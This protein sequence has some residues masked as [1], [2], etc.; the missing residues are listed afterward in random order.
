MS[1]TTIINYVLIALVGGVGSVLANKGIA[2]FNDGLRPIYPE[3]FDHKINRRELALTSFGVSFGLIIGFGIPVSIGSTILLAHSILLACDIFGTWTPDNKWGATAAFAIGAVYGAGLLL[4]LSWIVK[5][6]KMLPFNF[7]GA[8]S[9]LGSPILLAFC[10]FPAIA[11]AEQHNVKKGLITFVW[12]FV[13]YILISKFGIFNLGNGITITLNATGMALL[14]AMICMVYYAAKVKGTN[15]SNENL[16]NVFSA[17]IGRIKKNWIWLSLM[18]GLITAASSELILAV[19]VLPQQLLIKGQIQEAAMATFARAIGFIPLVFS[20][21]IVTGVYGMAGT[22]L[23][24]AIGLL[25]KGQPLVAFIAGA[26]WMWIEVQALGATAKGMDKFPGL[27]DMGDHIRTSLMETI[28]TSL[29]IGAAIACNKMA[30]N[31]GFFWVIGTWLLNK[32][33]KKPLVDMAVGPIATIAL[34]LLLNILRIV[35]LF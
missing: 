6:F 1:M 30:P 32:K 29:L 22:T 28:S 11:V 5:L 34:G 2:V 4:G 10:A 18:G 13:T 17:R 20:T 24:F 8:L 26:V 23:I 35:H 3:Y 33:M 16:V 21:A 27:R 31:L 9:L 12:T 7:F 15:N 19:D 25:L 14:V